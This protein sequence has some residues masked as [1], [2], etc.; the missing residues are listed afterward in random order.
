VLFQVWKFCLE[1]NVL[2]SGQ[3]G[4]GL[5]SVKGHCGVFLD[6]TLFSLGASLNAGIANENAG[7]NLVMD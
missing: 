2:D 3:I 4:P 1:V 7:V 6:K 5:S